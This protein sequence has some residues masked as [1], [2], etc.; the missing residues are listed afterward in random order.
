MAAQGLSVF[1]TIAAVVATAEAFPR[2]G[3]IVVRYKVPRDIDVRLE[4]LVGV[5]EHLT[6]LGDLE[7]FHECLDPGWHLQLDILR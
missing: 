3:K 4:H 2:L 7:S 6:V 5:Q 1:S